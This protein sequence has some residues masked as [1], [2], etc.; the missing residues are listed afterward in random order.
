MRPPVGHHHQRQRLTRQ[1]AVLASTGRCQ[2]ALRT[3]L[4]LRIASAG[5]TAAARGLAALAV[6][7]GGAMRAMLVS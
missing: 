6:G 2:S 4:V 7:P 5:G 1:G 3:R